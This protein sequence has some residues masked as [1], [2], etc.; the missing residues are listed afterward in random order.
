MIMAPVCCHGRSMLHQR[1]P[2]TKFYRYVCRE[3]SFCT[4]AKAEDVA[5]AED[6]N[7]TDGSA[8]LH[9]NGTA[10][11]HTA[12]EAAAAAQEVATDTVSGVTER[13]TKATNGTVTHR[14]R[15]GKCSGGGSNSGT[16]GTAGATNGKVA[17]ARGSPTVTL[18]RGLVRLGSMVLGEAPSPVAAR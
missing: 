5:T 7:G 9:S 18:W 11:A 6:V 2:H 13:V 10:H 16:S 12:D 3:P 1:V 15:G 17:A 4:I 8:D 14:S